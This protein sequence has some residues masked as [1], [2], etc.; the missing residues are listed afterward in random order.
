VLEFGWHEEKNRINISKHG[1]SFKKAQGIF[2]GEI[3][4]TIDDRFDY[5]ETR[6]ISIG[7]VDGVL[8]LTVVHTDKDG[9][10][11]LISARRANK[12][13]RKHYEKTIR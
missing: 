11:W 2:Y 1:I 8:L 12:R 10:I 4:T 7:L 5:D 6:E 9:K 3:V 13:E